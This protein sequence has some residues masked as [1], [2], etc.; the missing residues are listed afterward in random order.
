MRL[1]PEE[2]LRLRRIGLALQGARAA[3]AQAQYAWDE[4]VLEIEQAY[5]VVGKQVR[6]DIATGELTVEGDGGSP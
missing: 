2:L 1:K 4:A 6:V 5:G 3:L